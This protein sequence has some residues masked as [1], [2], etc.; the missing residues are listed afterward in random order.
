[1]TRQT[2]L[3]LITL[4]IALLVALPMTLMMVTTALPNFP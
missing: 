1:M 2:R 4:L 3:N